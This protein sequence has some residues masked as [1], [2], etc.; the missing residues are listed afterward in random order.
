MVTNIANAIPKR[1]SP[2]SNNHLH[3]RACF[4]DVM[5]SEIPEKRFKIVREGHHFDSYSCKYGLVCLHEYR[6]N[7]VTLLHSPWEVTGELRSIT[8]SLRR[9]VYDQS[10]LVPPIRGIVCNHTA[11][12]DFGI[13]FLTR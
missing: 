8:L 7:P 6:Y 2:A 11:F 13:K 1:S 5:S 9:R 10:R 3:Y 4:L 12:G